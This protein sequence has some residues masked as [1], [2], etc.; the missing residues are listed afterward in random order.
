M[1]KLSKI[2]ALESVK[3]FLP[4]SDIETVIKVCDLYPFD[5]SWRKW[6]DHL[7]NYI[8]VY[9]NKKIVSFIQSPFDKS[10]KIVTD[11]YFKSPPGKISKLSKHIFVSFGKNNENNTNV[12]FVWF[13]GYDDRLRLLVYKDKWLN[14]PPLI[15]GIDTI[16]PIIKSFHV[17]NF[18]R[19]DIL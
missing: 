18:C 9:N 11:I 15:S 1:K 2:K 19:S 8:Q 17:D 6:T 13:L 3:A 4:N 14:Y 10:E 16:R 7:G 12:C 5:K